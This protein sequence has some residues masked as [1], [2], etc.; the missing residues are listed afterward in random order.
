MN[1]QDQLSDA[2]IQAQL[3]VLPDWRYAH[4]KLRRTYV[5]KNY[6]ETMAFVNAIAWVIHREDH[7]PELTVT[8]DR[9]AA[10][11]DT[12]SANGISLNDFIAA[13]HLDQVYGG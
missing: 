1:P 12:H 8:Y 10:A 9:V 4:G 7:H 6:H 11:F 13:A 5:F 3:Q 2:Q